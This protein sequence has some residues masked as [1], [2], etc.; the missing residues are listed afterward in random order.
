[1]A[2][3]GELT[4]ELTGEGTLFDPSGAELADVAYRINRRDE[5]DLELDA[6]VPGPVWAGELFFAD[7]ATVVPD[8]GLYVLRLEDGTEG[9][10]DLAAGEGRRQA[11]FKGVGVLGRPPV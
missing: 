10:I 8:P 9:D 4:D 2:E 11:A 1:M 3:T 7:E 5:A 6:D